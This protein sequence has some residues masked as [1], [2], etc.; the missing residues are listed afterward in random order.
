MT[1]DSGPHH[2]I[3]Q[4]TVLLWVTEPKSLLLHKAPKMSH[5]YSTPSVYTS[6]CSIFQAL[7]GA[8]SY[9]QSH[10]YLW[11]WSAF[12]VVYCS[13]HPEHLCTLNPSSSLQ[14]PPA[15]GQCP[16]FRFPGDLHRLL[17]LLALGMWVILGWR[18]GDN[19]RSLLWSNVRFLV[20]GSSQ[21]M[22]PLALPPNMSEVEL[23]EEAGKGWGLGIMR[24][25][26]CMYMCVPTTVAVFFLFLLIFF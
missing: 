15:P 2:N 18:Q 19:S 13:F 26:G 23:V 11:A 16:C 9:H 14:G 5:K 1:L 6:D 25:E 17:Q 12:E 21:R 3:L 20:F 24:E 4:L 8:A 10:R 7:G 22:K